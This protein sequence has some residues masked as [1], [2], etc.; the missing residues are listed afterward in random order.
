MR[1]HPTAD[2]GDDRQAEVVRSRPIFIEVTNR[3][4][5]A[6]GSDTK[7]TAVTVPEITAN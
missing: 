1:K 6:G 5:D 4:R 2:A 7:G 3:T